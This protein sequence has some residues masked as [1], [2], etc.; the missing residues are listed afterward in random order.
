VLTTI[1]M[2]PTHQQQNS[3]MSVISFSYKNK[4]VTTRFRS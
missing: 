3:L 2:V 4:K 1:S